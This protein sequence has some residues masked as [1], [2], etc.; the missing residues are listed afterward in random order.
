MLVAARNGGGEEGRATSFPHPPRN[1][2]DL[3][4]PR[5][6]GRR[7]GVPRVTAGGTQTLGTRLRAQPGWLRGGLPAPL[8]RGASGE[9]GTVAAF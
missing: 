1:L 8:M 5:D 6:S 3:A 9:D 4:F 7:H 2:F